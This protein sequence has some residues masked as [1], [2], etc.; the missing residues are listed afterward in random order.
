M[1]NAFTLM[2]VLVMLIP[3]L[4]CRFMLL[5]WSI[6]KA[7]S[8]LSFPHMQKTLLGVFDKLV[9]NMIKYRS[10]HLFQHNTVHCLFC[11][12]LYTADNDN[13]LYNDCHNTKKDPRTCG[14][15]FLPGG[16]LQDN[17]LIKDAFFYLSA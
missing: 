9:K 12:V 11:K 3:T 2:I 14:G 8:T 5:K 15:P 7:P 13:K 16:L 1:I 17:L 10:A 6:N 4:K